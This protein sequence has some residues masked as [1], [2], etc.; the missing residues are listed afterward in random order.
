[1]IILR[2]LHNRFGQRMLGC[3]FHRSSDAQQRPSRSALRRQNIGHRAA[4]R[5]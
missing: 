1:M 5:R 3:A 2:A 4:G